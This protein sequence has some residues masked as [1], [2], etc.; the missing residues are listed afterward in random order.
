MALDTAVKC[1]HGTRA[2]PC[3]DG[4]SRGNQKR[5]T[6]MVEGFLS[7]PAEAVPSLRQLRVLRRSLSWPEDLSVRD[8]AERGKP[9]SFP[10]E[11]A[12]VS[13]D[14]F[15][16]AEAD[17]SGVEVPASSTRQAGVPTVCV[18]LAG[19]CRAAP[20]ER[21]PCDTPDSL[22]SSEPDPP[23]DR[24]A[25]PDGFRHLSKVYRSSLKRF[26]LNFQW[27][28]SQPN[29]AGNTSRSKGKGGRRFGRSLSHESGLPL[30]VEEEA[31]CA[32]K[33]KGAALMPPKSPLQS[34]RAY[35]RQI[36][37]TH[38]HWAM[39]FVGLRGKKESASPSPQETKQAAADSQEPLLGCQPERER[40]SY[41]HSPKF[42]S[43]E[44]QLMAGQDS[45]NL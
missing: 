8:T 12:V 42:T 31:D 1:K 24:S 25:R 27:A 13:G 44:P 28:S 43:V 14:L 3:L 16:L 29:E 5:V 20:P 37:I 7:C 34:F 39:A 6:E 9:D 26:T 10:D 40:H 19:S 22:H 30:R 4:G 15:R 17:Q 45:L 2:R 38:K 11:A 32:A 36:F 33:K 41:H 35:G 23:D 18:T 21:K